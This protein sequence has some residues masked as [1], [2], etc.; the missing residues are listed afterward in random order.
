[1]VSANGAEEALI[2]QRRSQFNL[3]R[4]FSYGSQECD[5]AKFVSQLSRRQTDNPKAPSP[6][7]VI[8]HPLS[9]AFLSFLKARVECVKVGKFRASNHV[10]VVAAAGFAAVLA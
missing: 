2:G 10:S 4:R 8:L 9:G 6:R 7:C 5:F 3:T 1:R